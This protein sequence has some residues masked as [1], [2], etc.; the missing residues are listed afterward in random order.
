MGA[1]QEIGAPGC[2]SVR[3]VAAVPMPGPDVVGSGD[4]PRP[5]SETA[6]PTTRVTVPWLVVFCT[7]GSRPAESGPGSVSKTPLVLLKRQASFF[8]SPSLAYAYEEVET[9]RG[10]RV[11][12]ARNS[13]WKGAPRGGSSSYDWKWAS[14]SATGEGR[15]PIPPRAEAR[16]KSPGC[17]PTVRTG[18]AR[19]GNAFRALR[20]NHS[21][22][23]GPGSTV[24]IC[25]AATGNVTRQPTSAKTH[26][27]NKACRVASGPRN[28]Q[29]SGNT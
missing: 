2:G 27:R 17:S 9:A 24:V 21:L 4:I 1:A 25:A 22:W 15:R 20:Q 11:P 18:S 5:Y 10:P 3:T 6:L 23:T 28:S 7:A 16:A 26:G 12:V 8:L 13:T 29:K 14:C 19:D